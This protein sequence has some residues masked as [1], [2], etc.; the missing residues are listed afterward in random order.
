MKNVRGFTV[1]EIIVVCVVVGII[2][3]I[4]TIAWNMTLQ[5]GRDRTREGEQKEWV[6]RFETYRNRFNVYPNSASTT[7]NNTAITGYH[8]LG[9]DFPSNQCGGGPMAT[10]A[11]NNRVMQELAKV[12]T[13]PEYSH[14]RVNGYVGPWA[15]Y[16][17]TSRIRVYQSYEGSCPTDTTNASISGAVVCY[18]DLSKDL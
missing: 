16:T 15:D 4:G 17:N 2:A 1:V 12:G 5:R 18:I 6:A 10:T 14:T 9:A 11:S 7:N 8:C 13:L 3:S